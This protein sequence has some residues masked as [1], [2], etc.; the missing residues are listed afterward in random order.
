MNAKSVLQDPFWVRY[1]VLRFGVLP[2][3]DSYGV[4]QK[5]QT[6]V[7]P[8]EPH[9][10]RVRSYENVT[11]KFLLFLINI[12]EKFS[13]K[14]Y[15]PIHRYRSK[16]MNRLSSAKYGE[17]KMRERVLSQPWKNNVLHCKD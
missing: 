5:V 14:K 10:F 13:M 6:K 8:K 2:Y 17:I 4:R 15:Y 9:I 12:H 16:K 11:G 7:K 3:H 1:I